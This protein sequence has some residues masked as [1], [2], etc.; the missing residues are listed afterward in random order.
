MY[1]P[2]W[3]RSYNHVASSLETHLVWQNRRMLKYCILKC[4]Q[5]L[6]SLAWKQKILM[7]IIK[8]FM[9]PENISLT[10]P[11]LLIHG[12]LVISPP[13]SNFPQ[14]FWTV[15]AR[16]QI[17]NYND[18]LLLR[19]SNSRVYTQERRLSCVLQ[20]SIPE[21]GEEAW[22]ISVFFWHA[23]CYFIWDRIF[24]KIENAWFIS[25]SG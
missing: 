8:D 23:D 17:Q 5:D 14:K 12:S 9:P 13:G 3:L 6:F 11:V 22:L 24:L 25:G 1:C 20:F 4:V 7:T 15:F 21:Q 10:S 16:E 2:V 18:K 19:Y